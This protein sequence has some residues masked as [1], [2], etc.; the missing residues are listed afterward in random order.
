MPRQVV[1]LVPEE[2][3]MISY[4]WDDVMRRVL[5]LIVEKCMYLMDQLRETKDVFLLQSLRDDGVLLVE[6]AVGMTRGQEVDIHTFKPVV[7]HQHA[8]ICEHDHVFV[9]FGSVV[10]LEEAIRR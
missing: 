9:V 1:N 3:C 4:S 10:H 2:C 6:V 8:Q 7:L 5:A